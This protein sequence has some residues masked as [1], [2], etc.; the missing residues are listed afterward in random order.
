V[1]FLQADMSGGRE[2]FSVPCCNYIDTQAFPPLFRVG[3]EP[4]FPDN[5]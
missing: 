1:K 3:T 4:S 2:Q 5:S